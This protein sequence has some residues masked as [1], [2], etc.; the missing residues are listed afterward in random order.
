MGVPG[1]LAWV[2]GASSGIGHASALRLARDGWTVALSGRREAELGDTLA[3]ITAEGGQAITVPV[4]ASLPGDVARAHRLI[5][6]QCGDVSLLL[7]SAG[8][9][10]PSRWWDDLDPAAVRRTV[11]VNMLSVVEAVA[12]V[13]PG[14][15]AARAGRIVVLG[16]WAGWRFM[17]VAGAAYSGSKQAL[18]GVVESINDQEGRSG[19]SATLV[20][21]AEVATEIMTTRPSP[22][23][24]EELAAMLRPGDVANMISVIASLPAHVCINEIVVSNVLNGIYLRDSY[25]HGPVTFAQSEVAV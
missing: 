20:I 19:I 14:M 15:R 21:P 3:Q 2:I 13:L 17:S 23:S 25:Y 6:D 4:D 9:N 18:S 5:A 8:T 16:S 12:A 11:E 22:P 1:R 7:H 10:V 24:A